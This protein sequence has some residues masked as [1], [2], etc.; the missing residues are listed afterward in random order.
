MGS[1]IASTF[2][3]LG[4]RFDDCY[5]KCKQ[6]KSQFACESDTW[7]S[8]C[9]SSLEKLWY[10]GDI[11]SLHCDENCILGGVWGAPGVDK[12]VTACPDDTV[13][14]ESNGSA[15][16]MPF[17]KTP[18]IIIVSNSVITGHDPNVKSEAT[19][20]RQAVLQGQRLQ[21]RVEFENEGEGSA[22]GVYF[23]DTLNVNLLAD[24]PEQIEIGPVY[25][26]NS[27]EK[28]GEP[29]IYNPATRTITWLVGNEGEV[30]PTQ[31]GYAIYQVNVRS[32][33]ADGTVIMNFA[34]VYF[35]SVP[36]ATRTNGVIKI[37]GKDSDGDGVVDVYDNCPL[38]PN[39]DQTDSDG[40][41]KGDVCDVIMPGDLNWDEKVTLADAILSLQVLIRLQ[42]S[43]LS[44][45][46]FEG[47]VNN[48]KK[49]GIQDTVYILQKLAGLRD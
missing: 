42:Q 40:D 27:G 18:N 16:C 43:T 1:E 24:M 23:T 15:A 33:I 8:H 34:T 49:I 9:A 12:T 5:K 22:F 4:L 30:G 44:E 10:G 13:C 17:K 29:G 48:D 26:V 45:I 38:A 36:E 20:P 37:V 31:G 6:D 21:Y 32:D 3:D 19:D 11:I 7:K 41:G 35:A 47:D 39:P 28:I 25:D 14:V 2:Y 46:Y